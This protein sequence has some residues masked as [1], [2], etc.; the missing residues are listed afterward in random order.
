MGE[1]VSVW[2]TVCFSDSDCTLNRM[3]QLTEDPCRDEGG[4]QVLQEASEGM[5]QRQN[6]IVI[7]IQRQHLSGGQR[8]EEGGQR[9]AG[10]RRLFQ[11]VFLSSFTSRVS[12]LAV[13]L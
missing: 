9:T 2:W 8:T 10:V 6:I 13:A 3:D 1:N 5:S 12:T 11:Y 4:A 7:Q